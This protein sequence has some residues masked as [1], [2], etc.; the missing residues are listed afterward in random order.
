MHAI[1]NRTKRKWFFPFTL[2]AVLVLLVGYVLYDQF[3]P[4]AKLAVIRDAPAFSLQD[5]DGNTVNSASFSGQVRLMEFIFTNCPDICPATTFNMV[6]I[7]NKLE[8]EGLTGRQVKMVATTFDPERDTPEAMKDYAKR[9][10]MDLSMWVLLRG[11]EAQTSQVTK[12]YGV[13]VQKLN[14]GSFV[15]TTTS[16]FLIDG[17]Q[18]IRKVYRMG[19]DMDLDQIA[20]DIR[21]LVRELD[22]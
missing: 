2:L 15:H 8:A 5:L 18:R 9:L 13:T 22:G 11:D 17:N 21:S 19:N 4:K 3:A 14:D 6:Q 16:L 20:G 12:S 1:S 7:Q 10:K